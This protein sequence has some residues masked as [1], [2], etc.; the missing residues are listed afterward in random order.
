MMAKGD[1]A[2]TRLF[3]DNYKKLLAANINC[4]IEFTPEKRINLDGLR[5][6]DAITLL[7]WEVTGEAVG[8][9]YILERRFGNP[10][11]KFDSI[12]IIEGRTVPDLSQDYSFSDQND[13]P[14]TSWYRLRAL[15]RLEETHQL[16]KI[17]GY[18]NKVKVY[19]NPATSS[20]MR[21]ELLRFKTNAPTSLI[22]RDAK[23]SIVYTRQQIFLN[24]NK[25]YQLQDLQLPN[26][27]YHIQV[28]NK[29]NSGVTTFVIQ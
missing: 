13:F 10:N 17:A 24:N 28:S 23:G 15:N 18:D 2:S 25:Y 1:N 5:I 21:L 12:G 9:R 14:G 29:F 27:A 3:L 22:I 19:P 6:N 4:K 26:G 8:T 16:V 7:K 20:N 11:G